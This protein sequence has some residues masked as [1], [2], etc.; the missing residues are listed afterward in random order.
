MWEKPNKGREKV[1][2]LAHAFNPS[3]SEA[4]AGRSQRLT[5]G[6]S[7]EKVPRQGYIVRPC[8]KTR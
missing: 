5:T 7:V 6:W 3:S 2:N 8:H 4:E 1:D